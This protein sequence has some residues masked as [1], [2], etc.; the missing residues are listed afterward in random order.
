MLET[1]KGAKRI[2]IEADLV[3][4]QGERFQPTGFPDLG[5]ATYTLHNGTR[6]LLVES[7][8]SMANRLEG[9]IIGPDNELIPEFA[10]LSYIRAQ[11]TK[12][13]D[14]TTN[15][16]LEA[17]RIN[18]PFIITDKD[19][20]KRFTEDAAYAKNSPIHWQKAAKAI[21]KYDVNSLIHG[22][23]L[24]NLLD[25]RLKIPRILSAFIEARN[26][27]EVVSGGVKN[28]PIDPTGTLRAKEH[29]KDVYGNVPYQRVAFTAET[30]RSYF[31]LDV[32][33][34]ESYALDPN[35]IDL[36]IALA[37]YKIRALLD[38]G[39]RLRTACHLKLDGTVQVT[40]PPGFQLPEKA[41]L[42]KTVQ[43]KIKK[44]RKSLFADPP[45]TEI[46]TETVMKKEKKA[47][48]EES[49]ADD[50]DSD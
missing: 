36:L 37:L 50:T 25:G 39:L 14:T 4:V 34:L 32:G 9:T 30:I 5:A 33:L 2:L 42:V 49:E 35:G 7:E 22:V 8:Q 13:A 12:A 45:V 16:L 17:H 11:L 10:G 40:D 31:N 26:V 48:S 27:R 19:F 3:P 20:Q 1:L 38:A 15:S 44:C 47:D 23:F 29:D 18:S 24:A 41:E 43:A 28:N 21:F 6:M 46:T